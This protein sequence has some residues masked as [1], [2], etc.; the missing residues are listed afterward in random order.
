MPA[1]A[2][3]RIL[4]LL[5]IAGVGVLAGCAQDGASPPADAAPAPE[6][7]AP[8]A[9]PDPSSPYA[10]GTYSADGQYLAPSGPES[11]TVTVTL[12]GGVVQDVVV[13]GHATDGTAR[14]Y[15]GQFVAGVAA[16]VVG[17]PIEGLSVDRVAGSSLTSGG[18]NQ[19]IETIR[20]EA[21][22]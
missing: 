14:G 19:A 8:P 1:S 15:Q 7:P 17:R 10:D 6:G 13:E 20:V 9:E 18:F 16:Q 4:P 5:A 12:E 22:R 11:V 2:P 3:I 21:R